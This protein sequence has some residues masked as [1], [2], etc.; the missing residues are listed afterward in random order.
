MFWRMVKGTLF[1]QHSK[2]LMIAFTVALGASLA[3]S[4]INVM[5]G[6]G[7]KVNSELKTYGANIMV[8]AQ[9]ASL[10]DDVYGIDNSIDGEEA[11]SFLKEEELP[12]I[13]TIFWGFNIKDYAPY[14]SINADLK[15]E[16]N[17]KKIRLIGTWIKKHMKINTGEDLTTGMSNLKS[18]WDID[19]DWPSE[20][21]TEA[22]MV[23]ETLADEL[24]IKVGDTL[25]ISS[26]A[27][28]E[29]FKVSGI[30]SSGDT[31]DDAIYCDL[32]RAQAISG[33]E[34]KVGKIEVSALTT[35]DNDLARKA[36]INPKSL[37]VKEW[38]AWYCTAYVS[39]ISY[40]IQEVITDSVAKPVRKVAESEGAILR[41]TETL[42]LLIT[43]LSLLGSALGISNLVTAS[44]ME[45]SS[46]IGLLKAIGAHN[47]AVVVVILTEIVITGLF[48]G[49]IGYGIG[50]LFTQLIAYGVFSSSIPFSP[51]AIPIIAIM[52]VVVTILGSLPAIKYLLSLKP[53]EVLHGR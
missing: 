51:L 28:S 13:K 33:L 18:W 24:G 31:D 21:E 41:K 49:V 38:E 5:M 30:F 26:V 23:G 1:R 48:G 4:M 36:A 10:L 52:V 45:R 29:S 11:N 2:M 53:A 7:D 43:I 35:P 47:S 9:E 25:T 40:Q 6:V 14:L 12:L 42:M 8:Q 46:E 15:Y 34:G 22:C 50:L 39:A 44:V 19:G 32:N 17:N 37:T 16:N 27:G 3:T 20:N